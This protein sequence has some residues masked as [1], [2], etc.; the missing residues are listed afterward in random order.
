MFLELAAGMA[1]SLD[2]DAVALLYRA[3]KPLV[4]DD[5]SPKLQKRAYKVRHEAVHDRVLPP[6]AASSYFS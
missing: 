2:Q 4:R 5:A 6:S 3:A 1:P